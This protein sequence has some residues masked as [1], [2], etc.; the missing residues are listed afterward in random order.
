ML[1][2]SA[3]ILEVAEKTMPVF[4]DT[5]GGG[6]RISAIE[7]WDASEFPVSSTLW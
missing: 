6:G 2:K 4:H 5:K 7:N 3:Q 1:C